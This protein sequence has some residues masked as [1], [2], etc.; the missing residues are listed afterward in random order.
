MLFRFFL[1]KFFF[2]VLLNFCSGCASLFRDNTEIFLFKRMP[3]AVAPDPNLRKSDPGKWPWSLAILQRNFLEAKTEILAYLRDDPGAADAIWALALVDWNL[4]LWNDALL[5]IDQL[6]RLD[7][8]DMR[9]L[10]LRDVIRLEHAQSFSEFTNATVG[11]SHLCE[12]LAKAPE[13]KALFLACKLNEGYAYLQV[14]NEPAAAKSF[15]EAGKIC[16]SCLEAKIGQVL[17]MKDGTEK[18]AIYKEIMDDHP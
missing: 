18:S 14:G 4:G 13:A 11:L 6:L 5:G 2:A 10:H 1:K 12:I 17:T 9:A 8:K 7:P 16:S 3:L 15:V